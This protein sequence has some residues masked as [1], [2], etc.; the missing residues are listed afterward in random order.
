MMELKEERKRGSTK[1]LMINS[2]SCST[3]KGQCKSSKNRVYLASVF[4]T[5]RENGNG[6]LLKRSGR[7]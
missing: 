2:S 6:G 1:F 4:K 5:A 7:P 3:G